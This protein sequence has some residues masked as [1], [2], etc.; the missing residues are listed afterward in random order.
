M[1]DTHGIKVSKEGFDV[2]TTDDKNLVFNSETNAFKGKQTGTK[3]GGGNVAHGLAYTPIF[4]LSQK[5]TDG[6]S[7]TRYSAA[8]GGEEAGVDGTNL[9]FVSTGTF[10]YYLLYQQAV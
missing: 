1:A 6:S 7:I 10:R 4:L 9:N 3:T 2:K 5:T 8:W